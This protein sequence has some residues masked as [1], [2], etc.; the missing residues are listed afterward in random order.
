MKQELHFEHGDLT[1]E[2]SFSLAEGQSLD[3]LFAHYIHEYNPDRMEAY[4]FRVLLGQENILTLFA[5]DNFNQE[6]NST[7]DTE[8]LP[9]KKYKVPNVPLQELFK[10]F[11]EINFTVSTNNYPLESLQVINK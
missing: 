8:K 3:Q 10:F 6:N 5:I 7:T 11:K 1:G 9:V 2:I 4:A